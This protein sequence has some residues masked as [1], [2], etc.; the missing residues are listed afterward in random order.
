[1]A[2]MDIKDLHFKELLPS[3]E[4]ENVVGGSQSPLW[5]GIINQTPVKLETASLSDDVAVA[6]KLSVLDSCDSCM[7]HPP[8]GPL[9]GFGPTGEESP[10]R[11][12]VTT[13]T[14]FIR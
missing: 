12:M 7:G 3:Q 14:D 10:L 8:L 13:S 5:D 9:P 1:M 4:L 11:Y 2:K 6:T